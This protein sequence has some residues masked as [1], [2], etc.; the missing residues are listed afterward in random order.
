MLL[1]YFHIILRHRQ[2]SALRVNVLVS[3]TS[4]RYRLAYTSLYIQTEQISIVLRGEKMSGIYI[5]IPFCKSKCPY[6]DFYS[7]K[8]KSEEMSRYVEALL[9]EINTLSRVKEFV[10][11]PF[12]AN[13][14][15]LGGGT[16]SILQG[17]ELYKIIITAKEKFSI[18]YDAE[19]TI[20]CNPN[21]DIEAILPYLIKA[22]VNR[23]SLGLQSAVDKERK[24]LGRLS[25]KARVNEVIELLK[26]NGMTNI[27]LDVMLGIPY[28]T[29]ESLKET[30]DFV[31]E[32]SVPHVSAY[33][34][35]IE[36]GTHFYKN[37]DKYDFPDDEK[38]IEFYNQC[39]DTLE[40]A[41]FNHYEISNFSKDGYESRHNTKYWELENYL[42]IGPGAHSYVNKKRFY[43]SADTESFI[44]GEKAVF[45][46]F[47][48]DAEEYIMLR[49]RLKKG[50]LLSELQNL[51]GEKTLAKIKEKAPFLKEQGLV[52][53]DGEKLS[54]T[55]KGF[56]L[57]NSV[58]C[59]F[60]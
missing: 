38:T 34:L 60:I 33:M 39:A 8:C 28:Q 29:K 57:S 11:E 13:T 52:N 14:L 54:L 16:P 15:Y 18:G 49:I 1:Y 40:K 20:E 26:R 48:G 19:I 6:C 5:H 27:S 45:D 24:T 23:I 56:L 51:Y 32:S 47:G 53:F 44:N 4:V 3:S 2:A 21:S 36:E 59:E 22:G 50:L 46:D 58:I 9:N 43:F 31:I 7:Y 55:R 12:T 30:L 37:Y 25:D 10:K 41:G 42:G 35:K 17:E